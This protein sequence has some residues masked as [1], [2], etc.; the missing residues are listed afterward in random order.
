MDCNLGGFAGGETTGW[1]GD[2]REGLLADSEGGRVGFRSAEGG[3]G[4]A[5]VVDDLFSRGGGLGLGSAGGGGLGL[6]DP[7][8]G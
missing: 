3:A 8:V 7:Y 2:D 4:F 5:S 1:L 6:I